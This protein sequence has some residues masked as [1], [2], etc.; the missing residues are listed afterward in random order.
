MEQPFLVFVIVILPI[1]TVC[2]GMLVHYAVRPMIETLVDA[3]R[4]LARVMD[5]IEPG[6]TERLHRELDDLRDE[7]ARLR[8]ARDFDRA[9]VGDGSRPRGGGPTVGA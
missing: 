2:A 4:E 8:E 5:R 6:E 7:V 9:L 1:L 3:I